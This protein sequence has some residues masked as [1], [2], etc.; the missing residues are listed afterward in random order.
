[1]IKLNISQIC[2]IKAIIKEECNWYEYRYESK[3][4]GIRINK[5]GFYDNFSLSSK[6]VKKS[7]IENDNRMF[8]ECNKVFWYPHLEVTMTN[9]Q[10]FTKFFKSKEELESYLKIEEHKDS[11]WLC[12]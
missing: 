2:S 10:K 4:L 8:I 1:M 3:F 12:F 6:S 11:E 9:K 5:E 7:L